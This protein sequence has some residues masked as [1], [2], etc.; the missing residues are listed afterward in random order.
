MNN[1]AQKNSKNKN[2]TAIYII[3]F[4]IIILQLFR[5]I[6]S[7]AFLKEDYHSDEQW[8]FG[9]ANSYYEPYIYQDA[10]ET[11]FTH[12]DEWLSPDIFKNY[13]T[14]SKDQRFSYDSVF[15]NQSKDLHPPL[16][17]L[18]LHTICSFFPEKFSFWYGF[19]LNIIF[20]IVTQIFL[21]LLIKETVG[22][23]ITAISGCLL[24]GT[25]TGALNTFVFV[26]MYAMATMFAVITSFL[27]I[28]LY[29]EKNQKRYL[30]AI[31]LITVFGALTH[32]FFLV[33][34]GAVSACFCFFY[35]FKKKIKDLFIYALT[36][37]ASVGVSVLIFPATI[38]HIFGRRGH[39]VKFDNSWQLKLTVNSILSELF[40]VHIS[41][42]KTAYP[43]IILIILSCIIAISLPLA[44][45]FRNEEWFKKLLINIP[46]SVIKKIK[47]FS[48]PIIY[49]FVSV[50]ILVFVTSR[51]ISLISMSGYVDRYI[52]M[53]FPILCCAVICILYHIV[54]NIPSKIK[55]TT[56]VCIPLVFNLLTY[57]FVPSIYLFDK[58]SDTVSAAETIKDSN[59]IFISSEYWLITCMAEKFINCENIFCS[60][61]DIL[62]EENIL[63]LSMLESE[64]P[65]YILVSDTFFKDENADEDKESTILN[66]MPHMHTDNEESITEKE[67]EEKIKSLKITN[68]FTYIGYDLIFSRSFY[69]YKIS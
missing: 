61:I 39:I 8:S 21:F 9:L 60:N 24:Y 63:K 42:F 56:I 64:Q 2:N 22:S 28:K 44:F 1:K 41:L 47:S 10:D 26:R 23:D 33:F 25:S 3:L 66:A 48:F 57:I 31:F 11:C 67:F 40:A 6:Y 54:K 55:N 68:E 18:I 4:I 45:L 58:P 53:A 69:I 30:P 35:L 38:N 37:L 65:T 49:M 32:H 5:I 46:K 29:N 27:H 16:Y 12:K 51:T 34:A 52:F 20:F 59:C 43:T 7:F 15:Y 13:I 62:K 17:Y 14:V 19:S 36:L 50:C